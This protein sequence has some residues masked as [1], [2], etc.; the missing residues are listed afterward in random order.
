MLHRYYALCSKAWQHMT[1]ILMEPP[2]GGPPRE[3]FTEFPGWQFAD[4][5]TTG[6]LMKVDTK[7]REPVQVLEA[8]APT[9]RNRLPN[10]MH[11]Q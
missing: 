3:A 5:W 8:F 7:G 4:G 1:T 2:E 9:S 6:R 10:H 11:T